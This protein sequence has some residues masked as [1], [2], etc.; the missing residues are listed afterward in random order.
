MLGTTIVF[1]H[2]DGNITVTKINQDGY[3]SEYMYRDATGQIRVKIR[4]SVRK[5]NG[6]MPAA[7]RHNVEWVR[8]IFGVDGEPD[9]IRKIYFVIEQEP[10]DTDVKD[11]DCI[12]DLAIASS[13]AFVTSLLGWSS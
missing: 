11:I 2:A 4:H 6:V 9:Q 3:G 7:D 13:G 10:S 1:P 5:A 8:T 12:C